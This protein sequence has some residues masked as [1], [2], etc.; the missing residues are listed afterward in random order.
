[1]KINGKNIPAKAVRT[2]LIFVFSGTMSYE[3]IVEWS[4]KF[5][6]KLKLTVNDIMGIEETAG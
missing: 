4:Q 6:P 3:D 5:Y 2:I 1:M